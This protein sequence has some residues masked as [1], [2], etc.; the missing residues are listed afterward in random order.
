M[1]TSDPLEIG[2]AFWCCHALL[3]PPAWVKQLKAKTWKM[4]DDLE[5]QLY[6]SREPFRRLMHREIIML[7]GVLLM[8]PDK[9][10]ALFVKEQ[11]PTWMDQIWK[12]DRI[13]SP[14][15]WL[16]T[17]QPSVWDPQVQPAE[18]FTLW[19]AASVVTQRANGTDP[20]PQT[21][22]FKCV[23]PSGP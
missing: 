16:L 13:R 2:V 18:D 14:N 20:Q 19:G 21:P 11:I 10:R 1:Q 5:D 15:S 23:L 8:D 17:L 7:L 6:W 4:F 9:D 3:V 22:H 12:H